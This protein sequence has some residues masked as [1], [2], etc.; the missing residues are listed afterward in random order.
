[1]AR[2]P[3]QN[4]VRLDES[5]RAMLFDRLNA[6]SEAESSRISAQGKDLRSGVRYHYQREALPIAVEH[7][8]GG[9]A[10]LMVCARNISSG[11]IGLI[12]GGFLHPNTRCKIILEQIDGSRIAVD[13]L[14]RSSRHLQGSIHEINVEFTRRIDIAQFITP[15]ERRRTPQAEKG[16]TPMLR[17]SI[18]Y[19]QP[20]AG[21]ARSLADQVERTGMDVVIVQRPGDAIDAVRKRM[22]DSVIIDLD[23]GRDDALEVIG[24]IR[25]AG[26]GGPLLALAGAGEKAVLDRA[27]GA[28]ATEGLFKPVRPETLSDFLA[29]AAR[30]AEGEGLMASESEGPAAAVILNFQDVAGQLRQAVDEASIDRVRTLCESIVRAAPGGT[31]QPLIDAASDILRSIERAGLVDDTIAE[32]RRLAESCAAAVASL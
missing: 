28:G 22:F 30:S 25:A 6:V 7:P 14:V 3:F 18:L 20:R 32:V 12:H 1:M 24:D 17:G 16:D 8:G 13:G 26:F 11:G 21:D 29:R 15:D 10:T 2:R 31:M 5:Q 4:L 23:L 9:F 27:R 19:L